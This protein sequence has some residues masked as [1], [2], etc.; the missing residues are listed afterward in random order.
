[1]RR[2]KLNNELIFGLRS[3]NETMQ[4]LQLK[5]EGVDAPDYTIICPVEISREKL[6]IELQ[7]FNPVMKKYKIK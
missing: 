6:M 2:E 5:A 7:R 1:M 3:F 4:R